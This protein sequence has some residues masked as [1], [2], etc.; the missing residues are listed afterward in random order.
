[1][2]TTWQERLLKAEHD[3]R[4]AIADSAQNNAD[5]GDVM[6]ALVELGELFAEQD[7][8]LVELAEIISEV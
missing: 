8:A 6:N 5:M 3:A 1:M 4:N 2:S 7:D